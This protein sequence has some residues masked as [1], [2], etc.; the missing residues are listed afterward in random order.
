MSVDV[1]IEGVSYIASGAPGQ[2]MVDLE[3]VSIEL[4]IA[5]QQPRAEFK[6]VIWNQATPRPK[7]GQE[8]VFYAADGSREFGGII[9]QVEEDEI[10][11]TIMRYKCTCGDYTRWFDRHVVRQTYNAQTA[12]ALINAMVA[13][14]VNTPGNSRVFTTN[15]VQSAPALPIIQFYYQP[16]SQVMAQLVQMLGWGW[17]VDSYRDVHFYD[18]ATFTSP[19][20]GN[21]LN[22]DDL[23]DD[24]SL[25]TGE[26]PNWVNLVIGED[27]TQLKNRCFTIGVYIAQQ[28]LFSEQ[29]LGD[30][31]TTTFPMAYMAPAD[32][33][34]I[35]VTV[36][37]T[38]YQVALDQVN[39]QPGGPC[40]AQTAYVN[41]DQQ[42][43]RFCTA[44]AS[45]AAITFAYYPMGLTV[46]WRESK[47]SEAFMA[48]RDGTDG[49]YEYSTMDPSLSAELPT[50]AYE[51]AQ[52]TLNKYAFP[53]ETLSFTSF[54]Q[55]W[56]PGMWFN[57]SSARRFDGEMNV[58]NGTEKPFY[59]LT[60]QK[61]LIQAVGGVWTWQYQVEAASTPFQI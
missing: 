39:G 4:D 15:N 5:A 33:A 20:P 44:P 34:K 42:S 25:A 7:A 31:V 50:L 48:A 46:P 17:Y 40:E 28:Q 52:M 27:V 11:P 21:L 38:P 43:I 1:Q 57:F 29:H 32:L 10:E 30:G 41:F 8:I 13:Q 61:T 49:I 3:S 14:F 35:D 6:V 55:G 26:L 58:A 45:G 24:S 56:L 60:V 23:Y 9:L 59:V 2:W 37:G 47:T 18:A 36:A 12:D 51:R 22:A 53:Y 16:P 19:L 54:L